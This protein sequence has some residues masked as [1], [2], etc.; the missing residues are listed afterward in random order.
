MTTIRYKRKRGRE[1]APVKVCPSCY[2]YNMAAVRMCHDCGHEFPRVTKAARQEGEAALKRW[3]EA[4]MERQ[5]DREMLAAL[6]VVA[7]E[8]VE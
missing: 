8:G 7:A 2:V 4:E 5:A 6:E 3:T 1:E